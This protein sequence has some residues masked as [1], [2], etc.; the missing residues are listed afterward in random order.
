[1]LQALF[2]YQTLVCEITGLDVSNASLYDGHTAAA[3]ACSI[4]LHAARGRDRNRILCSQTVHPST[5]AVLDTHFRGLG[6]TIERVPSDRGVTNGDRLAEMLDES[7]AAVLIQSPNFYGCLE[8]LTGVAE[9]VHAAGSLLILSADPISLGLLKPPGEW[10][11]DIAVGDGQPLGMPMYFGGPSVG[12]IAV[13]DALLRKLPGRIVGETVDDRRGR[14]FV[15]TLQAREQHIKRE[16]ATS[17][18]CTNQS[19]AAIRAAIFLNALGR[20]GFTELAEQNLSKAHFL[21]DR[22]LEI[23]G[24]SMCFDRPFFNEFV[25]DVG[26]PAEPVLTELHSEG[27]LGGIPVPEVS[28]SAVLIA[29][30]EKRTRSEMDRY[31]ELLRNGLP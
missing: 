14:A 3:E 17:N 24:C 7:V 12:F 6:A 11:A 26:C 16:R 10:G 20:K 13:T 30:S 23:P 21:A 4:A 1:V 22:L 28:D 19:L 25:L 5:G 31:V 2:E 15:L 18:I 8:D 29:V 9:R 27:I